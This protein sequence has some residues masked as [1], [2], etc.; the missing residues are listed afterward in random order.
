MSYLN[1]PLSDS[2]NLQDEIS[3]GISTVNA[4]EL[5]Y[6]TNNIIYEVTNTTINTTNDTVIGYIHNYNSDYEYVCITNSGIVSLNQIDDTNAEIVYSA[7][8]FS[9]PD[10]ISISARDSENGLLISTPIFITINLDSNKTPTTTL[11][12][13]IDSYIDN[14]TL[15]IRDNE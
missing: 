12:A 7:N 11:F 2:I 4:V 13:D 15:Y 6:F 8:I 9:N 5:E 1:T 3:K 10:V 14:D